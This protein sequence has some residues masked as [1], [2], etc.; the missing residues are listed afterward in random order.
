VMVSPSLTIKVTHTHF[1]RELH[2]VTTHV[3]DGFDFILFY[4]LLKF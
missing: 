3:I 4:Y 2:A 1:H